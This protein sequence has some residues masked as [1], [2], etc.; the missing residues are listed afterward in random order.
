MAMGSLFHN[1]CSC[2]QFL[3]FSST[4]PSQY[5]LVG[6]W[7]NAGRETVGAL[8]FGGASTQ[9][10]FLTHDRVEDK[11][12]GNTLRLYGQD[13]TLYT[14][15]FLCYGRDQMLRKLLAHLMQVS[16]SHGHTDTL[17]G[18]NRCT[19]PLKQTHRHTETASQQQ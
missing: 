12:K 13:Y 11:E 3:M 5:G 10:T 6:R 19:D 7:L 14:H 2:N 17:T 1:G 8:D 9:I 16:A 15:S 4:P 18:R